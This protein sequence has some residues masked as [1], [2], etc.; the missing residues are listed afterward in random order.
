VRIFLYGVSPHFLHTDTF[1]S[2]LITI[3]S[4]LCL[5]IYNPLEDHQ[6]DQPNYSEEERDDEKSDYE[7]E[8]EEEEEEVGQGARLDIQGG[9]A[10]QSSRL[11][12]G[13]F[14]G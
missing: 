2:Y 14:L 13:V 5:P 8:E 3:F 9:D 6:F 1:T 12:F 10:C 7:E 11:N 4:T